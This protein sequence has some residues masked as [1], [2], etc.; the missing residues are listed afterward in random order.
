MVNK[1]YLN[2]IAELNE[3]YKNHINKIKNDL[4]L[5]EN[6]LNLFESIKYNNELYKTVL[7]M[8]FNELK[9]DF[10][11][12]NPK[13]TVFDKLQIFFDYIG[14]PINIK[15]NNICKKISIIEK[16]LNIDQN[17]DDKTA[18]TDACKIGNDYC[19]LSFDNGIFKIYDNNNM[20]KE[21]FECMLYE[22]NRGINSLINYNNTNTLLFILK[23]LYLFFCSKNYNS[24]E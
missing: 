11:I 4:K 17:F 24:N 16:K 5:K 12:T 15:K 10:S 23:I 8:E 20:K 2:L 18:L 9:K 6:Y 21:K 22:Q 13:I 14:Q 19:C 7:N 3:L 1:F